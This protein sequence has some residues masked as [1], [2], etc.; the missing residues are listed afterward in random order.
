MRETLV[1]KDVRERG[2]SDLAEFC[3]GLDDL[4]GPRV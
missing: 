2:S 1:V 4:A 3:I